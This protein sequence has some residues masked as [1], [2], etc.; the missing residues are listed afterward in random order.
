MAVTPHQAWAGIE[1]AP[2]PPEGPLE[3]P[4]VPATSLAPHF[5]S[6]FVNCPTGSFSGFLLQDKKNALLS[7][8]LP[9]QPE[10]G[11]CWKRKARFS[12]LPVF[13]PGLTT[14]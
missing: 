13:S 14:L 5:P 8:L 2:S 10:L 3:R 11:L 6:V 1:I 12:T 4:V 9:K 7:S